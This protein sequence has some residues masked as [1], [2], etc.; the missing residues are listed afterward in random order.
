MPPNFGIIISFDISK[1]LSNGIFAARN[2][3]KPQHILRIYFTSFF[4]S[5][6][7]SIVLIYQPDLRKILEPG[8]RQNLIPCHKMI[9]PKPGVMGI[10]PII[11]HHKIRIL[12]N[13]IG[14]KTPLRDLL[15]ILLL[16]GHLRSVYIDRSGHDLDL[17]A[18]KSDNPL[19]E[20]LRFI[21]GKPEYND[22]R[23]L[24][25]LAQISQP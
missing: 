14:T 9:L 17:L 7:C 10:I 20:Y 25:I 24:R 11:A 1:Y 2:I 19:D 23:P 13:H 3:R 8:L 18:R 5:A 21:I 16:K 12:R 15:E 22:I 6:Y 4:L